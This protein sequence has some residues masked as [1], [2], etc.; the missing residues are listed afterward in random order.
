MIKVTIELVPYGVEKN[1]TTIAELFIDNRGKLSSE[2]D[3]ENGE[4][5][6]RYRGIVKND[7]E[8]DILIGEALHKR[9]DDVFKLLYKVLQDREYQKSKKKMDEVLLE[10]RL[11]RL[12]KN[13]LEDHLG[14]L[15]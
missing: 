15:K 7:G 14:G 8:T 12:E 4:Y 10:K 3:E 11:A 5:V 9:E 6:Y 1:K 13:N 2:N